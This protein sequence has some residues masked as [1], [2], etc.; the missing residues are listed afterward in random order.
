MNESIS[1]STNQKPSDPNTNRDVSLFVIGALFVCMAISSLVEQAWLDGS[2]WS[3][4]A[5]GLFML[6][7]SAPM[8]EENWKQPRHFA[9]LILFVI[10]VSLLICSPGHRSKKHDSPEATVQPASTDHTH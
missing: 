8:T 4:M 10:G 3:L 6:V 1:E 9:C 7:R 5:I 2:G